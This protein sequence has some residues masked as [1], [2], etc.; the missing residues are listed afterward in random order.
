[1]THGMF[2]TFAM[3]VTLR[4]SSEFREEPAKFQCSTSDNS[5]FLPTSRMLC[6]ILCVGL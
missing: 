6:I 2:G 3:R 5:V 4:E 1:M